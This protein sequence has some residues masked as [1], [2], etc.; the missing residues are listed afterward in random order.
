MLTPDDGLKIRNTYIDIKTQNI[1]YLYYFCESYF[2]ILSTY[3]T[4]L[5]T[6][7]KVIIK[8]GVNL[9]KQ[10]STILIRLTIVIIFLNY[11]KNI[12]SKLAETSY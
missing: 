11:P 3:L 5:R 9:L 2:E 8:W 6:S 10:N 12:S 1:Y 4:T 7:K